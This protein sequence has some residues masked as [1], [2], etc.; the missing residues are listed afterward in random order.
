MRWNTDEIEWGKIGVASWV[1]IGKSDGSEGSGS[2]SEEWV[3]FGVCF[4]VLCVWDGWFGNGKEKELKRIVWNWSVKKKGG[5]LKMKN[6]G[7]GGKDDFGWFFDF[8]SLCVLDQGS[9]CFCK[10]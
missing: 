7:G 2:G 1:L 3:E 6:D 5:A 4:E 8:K 9:L 10:P